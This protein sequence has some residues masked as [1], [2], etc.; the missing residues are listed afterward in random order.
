MNTNI[1][2]IAI[3]VSAAMAAS[4]AI[5]GTN[6]I[7]SNS[8]STDNVYYISGA[9]AQTPSLA[10]AMVNFC[11][12]TIDTYADTY[13]G[14]QS[15]I[16]YC[17][18]A[19]ASSG[20]TAG[21][22]FIVVKADNGSASGLDAALGNAETSTA[23]SGWADPT[24]VNVGSTQLTTTNTNDIV[25][26]AAG[27]APLSGVVTPQIGLSD[28][29]VNT[30]K[31]RGVTV[32]S[33]WTS[34]VVAGQGFGVAVSDKLYKMMQYDQ[35]LLAWQNPGKT[36]TAWD[37]QPNI[38]TEQYAGLISQKGSV[39]QK[40]LPNK[41]VKESGTN[42]ASNLDAY[43]VAP[44]AAVINLNVS[45]NGNNLDTLKI[46]R[47]SSGSGTTAAGEAYFLN[48]PCN[49][50]TSVN[51]V[52]IGGGLA[53]QY[54]SG[55]TTSDTTLKTSNIYGGAVKTNATSEIYEKEGSSGAVIDVLRNTAALAANNYS[56][57][58]LSLENAL[59]ANDDTSS[60]DWKFLKLNGVSPTYLPDG[61]ADTYQKSAI[62]DGKYDF[63]F[64]PEMMAP[65]TPS[66]PVVSF[67]TALVADLSN[68]A[69]LTTSYGVY[70]DPNYVGGTKVLG[71]T[72][73]YSRSNNPC[74]KHV[75]T[76]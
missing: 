73:H 10:K 14:N 8:V 13:D 27:T 60:A 37:S 32:P 24:N 21:T 33:S 12:A 66:A 41:V 19:K 20:L 44:S 76:W 42:T 9:T 50:G 25:G 36:L 71:Q 31:A 18:N 47:R 52:S 57:G 5:A 35:G 6:L 15:F 43:G 7:T 48:N 1:K 58:V 56:I 75:Y 30:W 64:E 63:A 3:A 45:S 17:S 16:Y 68:G 38:T 61:T 53:S 74:Q 54:S 40:L 4:S 11:N 22:K 62:L 65:A 2:K 39:W 69:N 59:P 67:L 28:V 23:S 34:Y 70:T 26:N 49:N 51:G 46:A 72:S 29:S 55:G